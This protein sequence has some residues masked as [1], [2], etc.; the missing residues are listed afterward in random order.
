M[1]IFL[2]FLIGNLLNWIDT[3]LN[4]NYHSHPQLTLQVGGNGPSVT[5]H[6][7]SGELE[8]VAV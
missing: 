6:V 8:T 4:A 3:S 7:T 1:A 5:R 2:R